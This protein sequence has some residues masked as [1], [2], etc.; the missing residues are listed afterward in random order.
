MWSAEKAE[1][2]A[3]RGY[4]HHHELRRVPDG[5][6]LPSKVPWL[7]HIARTSFKLDGG[8]HLSCRTR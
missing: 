1:E 2:Y 8:P 5:A 4:V 6:L 3:A 7:K